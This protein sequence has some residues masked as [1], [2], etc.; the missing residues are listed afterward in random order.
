MIFEVI[1][2]SPTKNTNVF[3]YIVVASTPMFVVASLIVGNFMEFPREGASTKFT[4][5]KSEFFTAHH[6]WAPHCRNPP[7]HS[8]RLEIGRLG[9]LSRPNPNILK[10]I[11]K[12]GC[13]I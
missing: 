12:D 13:I 3:C 6:T 1:Q 2:V 10:M 7:R 8:K 4:H 5:K 9:D 11:Q